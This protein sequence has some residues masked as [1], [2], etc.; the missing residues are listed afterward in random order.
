MGSEILMSGGEDRPTYSIRKPFFYALALGTTG[1]ISF[2]LGLIYGSLR[3]ILSS[4]AS[5]ISELE[6]KVE[7]LRGDVAELV[8]VLQEKR[9]RGDAVRESVT[10]GLGCLKECG[11]FLKKFGRV[12][13]KHHKGQAGRIGVLGG[14]REYTGAPYY[15]GMS[16]LNV[17]AE[18]A[19]ILASGDACI[20]I[21]SYSPELMV[22]PL[23]NLPPSLDKDANHEENTQKYTQESMEIAQNTP[24]IDHVVALAEEKIKS[25]HALAV[26]C[27]LGRNP[28]VGKAVSRIIQN[29]RKKDI[30]V[31][32]DADGLWVVCQYPDV[33]RGNRRVILTP[34]K[35]EFERLWNA[36][37]PETIQTRDLARDLKNLSRALEGVTIVRKGP[38]DMIVD[39][40]GEV[41]T[42]N[43]EGAPRRPGGLGDV[44]AGVTTAF[45][46][47][48]G[49][50]EEAKGRDT[51]AFGA[52]ALAACTVV[53]LAW[54]ITYQAKGRA[55]GVPDLL[56]R[57][58]YIVDECIA[59]YE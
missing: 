58:G 47:W 25:L 31:I 5:K 56:P 57:L 34:N 13:F 12:D 45:A 10:L 9:R 14:S 23:Y 1:G 51:S 44:L 29:M 4:N 42:C 6:A 48:A 46:A 41:Y 16:A 33:V 49:R 40:D 22:T 59:A 18:L 19:F 28:L 39:S 53:R 36:I 8:R 50:G 17:G 37:L 32:I 26:G 11:T 15:A 52:S 30:P 35:P 27:G 3:R 20:P 43:V 21:K 38:V 2:S 7:G 55:S 24:W 54:N